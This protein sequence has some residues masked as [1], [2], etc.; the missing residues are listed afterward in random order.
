VFPRQGQF[1]HDPAIL[2]ACPSA[3][4]AVDRISDLLDYELPALLASTR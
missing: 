2:A 1:A 3:D 4:V